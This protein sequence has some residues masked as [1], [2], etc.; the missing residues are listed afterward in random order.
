MTR[1]RTTPP[2]SS[3][4]HGTSGQ[5]DHRPIPNHSANRIS[6]N[7]MMIISAPVHSPDSRSKRIPHERQ[8]GC[9]R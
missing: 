6:V 2:M 8:V 1:F 4:V 5:V 7:A 3:N 9:S